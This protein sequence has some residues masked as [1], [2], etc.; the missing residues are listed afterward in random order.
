MIRILL[1]DDHPVLRHGMRTLLGNGALLVPLLLLFAAAHMLRQAPEPQARGR[2]VV[3]T[4]A[5]GISVLG[6]LDLGAGGSGAW[7]REGVGLQRH[8]RGKLRH[9]APAGRGR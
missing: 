3:G 2:V 1:V 8:L 5:L 9:D 6:L 7:R 4:I